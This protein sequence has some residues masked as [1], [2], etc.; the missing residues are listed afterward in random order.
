[1]QQR[2]FHRVLFT[3][4]SMVT[5]ADVIFKGRIENISLNGAMVSFQKEVSVRQGD[6][7]FLA[8]YPEGEDDAI[9][10]IAEVVHSS[11]NM[12]GMK[13]IAIDA[14]TRL[15]LYDLVEKATSEPE[16]L[17]SEFERLKGYLAGYLMPGDPS[18]Q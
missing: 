14:D 5:V 15:R 2:L 6:K 8:I 17:P 13:F 4:R 7:C 12:V 18:G 1:M 11:G 16:R 10:I 3:A 9:R